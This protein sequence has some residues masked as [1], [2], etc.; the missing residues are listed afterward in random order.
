MLL[1][2]IVAVVYRLYISL[3]PG[4]CCCSCSSFPLQTRRGN[5]LPRTRG[6]VCNC[7]ICMCVR[8][9]CLSSR[10]WFLLKK[11]IKHGGRSMEEAAAAA[12]ACAPTTGREKKAFPTESSSIFGEKSKR[13]TPPCC[14]SCV[15]RYAAREARDRCEMPLECI[16]DCVAV[17]VLCYVCIYVYNTCRCI[18]VWKLSSGPAPLSRAYGA[19]ARSSRRWLFSCFSLF[20]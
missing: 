12:A 18:Y 3:L 8:K 7:I 20:L 16:G 2:Y 1:L 4:R 5:S 13:R 6:R 17:A 9:K 19:G 15:Y 11:Y 10:F 14:F